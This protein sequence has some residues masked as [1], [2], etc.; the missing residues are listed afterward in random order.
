MQWSNIP[1]I[2]QEC[3]NTAWISFQEGSRPIGA[4]IVNTQGEIV[5]RGKSAVFNELSNTVIS[6]NEL[7]HAEV[8]AM[9]TLDNRIHK[10]VN[11]YVLYSTMEPCPLCFS[12]LYM[13][14]IKNLKYA[15]KDKYGGST[16][17]V[18]TTP[19]LSRKQIAIE[20]SVP[21]L[22]DFSI[23]LNVY[24]DL[25]IGYEKAL[26]VI[27]LM[28]EDYPFAV[29]LARKWVKEEKLKEYKNLNVEEVYGMIT[30]ELQ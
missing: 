1:H 23:L 15:A 28:E 13:S 19:Y 24:F 14:G 20:G 29:Q 25:K 5:A 10:K 9:L 2:W 26:P 7:A 8:N 11:D 4:V 12:A 17:L 27:A 21:I 18:G 3:F 22:E 16:N 30:Y 6:H